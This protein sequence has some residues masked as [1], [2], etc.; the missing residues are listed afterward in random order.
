[1]G[2][3]AKDV[4][5]VGFALFAMFFGAG[6]LIFPPF[7]G[8]A[9]GSNWAGA[10]FGFLIT[11]IGMP[12]L[13]IMA[14]S[15][16]G[17]TIDHFAGRVSPIFAKILG[18][19]VILAIGPL[20]AIPRTGATT[21]E[22]GVKPI[23]PGASPLFVSIIYFSI[24]LF[25][26][27]NPSAVIDK[28]GKILTPFLI[29]ILSL[30]IL[31]GIVSP[32]G[33]LQDTGIENSFSRGFTEGYQTMDTLVSIAF[34]EII[35]G[36]LIIKGYTRTRDQINLTTLAGLVAAA[37][38]AFVYGGLM[39][40]GATASGQLPGDTDRTILVVTI[41]ER[42]LGNPGR[43]ALGIAVALACLTTSIGLTA[44]VGEYFSKLFNEKL[45]YQTVCIIT[46]VFSAVFATMGV[47]SIVNF[48][49]PLLV[50]VYPVAMTLIVLNIFRD[51][52][53]NRGIYVGAVMGALLISIFDAISAI[54]YRISTVNRIVS[55]IPLSAQGFPWMIPAVLGGIIGALLMRRRQTV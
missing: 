34:A 44:T 54:G 53:K 18:V 51:F 10:L 13:G 55:Y 8:L 25:F 27:L 21:Y 9:S 42:L 15:R 29:V 4:L 20:L 45:S 32:I 37:G 48:A 26:V 41:V 31:K 43:I 11:G 5:V 6:N 19:V 12:L 30:I 16:A 39:Y 3:K 17:G 49:V 38:L 7:L 46:V 47:N 33:P 2:K 36:S 35:I 28:I 50:T 23:F 24:T 22:M 14:V 40:L 1:M 52:I